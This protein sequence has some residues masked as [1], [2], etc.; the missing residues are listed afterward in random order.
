[1]RF[2]FSSI[3]PRG[4]P[5]IVVLMVVLTALVRGQVVGF[6]LFL[7]MTSVWCLG[8]N[9]CSCSLV[10]STSSFLQ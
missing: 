10:S 8:K 3:H 5:V 4:L 1:M 2:F 6:E 9:V 7:L